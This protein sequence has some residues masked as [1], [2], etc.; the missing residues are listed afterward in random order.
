MSDLKVRARDIISC[1]ILVLYGKWERAGVV[2]YPFLFIFLIYTISDNHHQKVAICFG[3]HGEPTC[4]IEKFAYSVFW[5]RKVVGKH[6]IKVPRKEA[7]LFR[8]S[9]TFGLWGTA[10]VIKLSQILMTW[11]LKALTIFPILT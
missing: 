8:S 10:V 7:I 2:I 6:A 9:S 5:K 4:L 1:K 3:A 11:A